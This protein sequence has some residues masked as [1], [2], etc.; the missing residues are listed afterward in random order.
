M[1]QG[2][3]SLS[4]WQHFFFNSRLSGEGHFYCQAGERQAFHRGI[5]NAIQPLVKQMVAGQS[6]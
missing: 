3:A 6:P 2:Y 1:C 5:L 4:L